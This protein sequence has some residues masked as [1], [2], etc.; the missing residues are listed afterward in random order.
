[1]DYDGYVSIRIDA[2]TSYDL[3]FTNEGLTTNDIFSF[4]SFIY[5]APGALHRDFITRL[6]HKTRFLMRLADSLCF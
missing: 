2:A 5:G 4:L 6:S 1:M 3:L